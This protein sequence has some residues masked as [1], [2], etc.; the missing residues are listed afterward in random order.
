MITWALS[1]GNTIIY[2]L[3]CLLSV[4]EAQVQNVTEEKKI[5]MERYVG[6]YLPCFLFQ[7][8]LFVS[9]HFSSLD[10]HL[11]FLKVCFFNQRNWFCLDECFIVLTC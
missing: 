8:T 3:F 4:F 2:I 10:I 5:L 9:K 6:P 7:L 11:I 1:R